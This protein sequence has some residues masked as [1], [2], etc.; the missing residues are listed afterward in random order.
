MKI[1]A[2]AD[3][4]FQKESPKY[5][6]DNYFQTQVG[7]LGWI[8]NLANQI[9]GRLFIAG[10]I[11]DSSKAGYA[12]TNTLMRVLGELDQLPVACF[13]NHDTHYHSSELSNTPFGT[14][15]A[16]ETIICE[17]ISLGKV[18][19][20]MLNWGV[21]PAKPV[22]G[23]IN[24]LLG[25]VSVFKEAVPFWAED[26]EAYTPKSLRKRYPGY[27]YYIT[28]DIHD[29]FERNNVINPGSMCRMNQGQVDF[30]PR[31]YVLDTDTGK[32]ELHY[33]PVE[34]SENVFD[35]DGADLDKAKDTKALNDFVGALRLNESGDKPNFR[36]VLDLV[37]KEVK[38]PQESI[39]IIADI[40]GD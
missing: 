7:K 12:V 2:C 24:I 25:H 40:I 33:I 38:P 4:H 19:V 23:K 15:L 11:F 36:N 1:V 29:P 8:V 16:S 35:L 3:L 28:G 26:S 14:L 27:E 6:K 37:I 31:V 20:T 5:R 13:G 22:L 30:L 21:E 39:D 34:P 9:E 18:Q 17:D 32:I 10:D